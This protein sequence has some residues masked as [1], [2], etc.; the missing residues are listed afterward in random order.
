MDSRQ[1]NDNNSIPIDSNNGTS[2][3]AVFKSSSDERGELKM[4]ITRETKTGKSE[5]KILTSPNQ[6]SPTSS[7]GSGLVLSSQDLHCLNDANESIYTHKQTSNSISSTKE[8]GTSTSVGTITEPD[9]LGPCEPGTSVSLEGIVWQETEGGILV[10][11]V[12]WRGKTYVGALLDCT[13]HDWAP[14]RLC[15]SPTSDIDSKASKGVRPKRIVTRSNGAGLDEKNLLQT[16]GKLRN[17]KGRR[18]LPPND[19]PPCNKKLRESDKSSENLVAQTDSVSS[20]EN[21]STLANSETRGVPINTDTQST[22]DC[23][24]IKQGNTAEKTGPN[25]PL[26]IGCNEPNCSK[27]YRNVQGL[28]YHKTHAH[29][30]ETDTNNA[31]DSNCSSSTKIKAISAN[32]ETNED[33]DDGDIG[34]LS[35]QSKSMNVTSQPSDKSGI[36]SSVSISEQHTTQKL[37]SRPAPS[38][39]LSSRYLSSRTD[40]SSS[41]DALLNHESRSNMTKIP[42]LQE[43]RNSLPVAG[44]HGL[45]KTRRSPSRTMSDNPHGF[46]PS[47]N[48][49]NTSSNNSSNHHNQ[50]Q[51][52]QQQSMSSSKHPPPSKQSANQS[53]SSSASTDEGMKPSGTSTGPP[54]APHQQNCYFN[55]FLNPYNVG[56]LARPPLPIYDSPTSSPSAA[57]SKYMNPVRPPNPPASDSPSRMLNPGLPKN[58][59]FLPNFKPEP[60]ALPQLPNPHLGNPSPLNSYPTIG[61][62]NQPSIYPPLSGGSPLIR[63]PGQGDPLL[64]PSSQGLVPPPFF[65]NLAPP[66]GP[67]LAGLMNRHPVP[68]I[69]DDLQNKSQFPRRPN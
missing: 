69:M 56:C 34:E 2:G 4:R 65:P 41:N 15:D 36:E 43:R 42:D 59:P 33:T 39:K 30:S 63:L 13:K 53:N 20:V 9:C 50:Y 47:I 23:E 54:P 61:N 52:P 7:S 5:H 11:N 8:C 48:Q 62:P 55:S 68:G 10:V 24:S 35:Q 17:G 27:K 14:P 45:E 16:T 40:F 46:L 29:G 12:T 60:N 44:N 25:S 67:Q 6:K 31:S 22:T 3:R 28:L 1:K 64:P 32:V 38:P 18:I 57:F 37:D 58:F 26:L 66:L 49:N 21:V 19:L 51:Q